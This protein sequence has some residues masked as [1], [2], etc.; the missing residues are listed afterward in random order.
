VVVERKVEKVVKEANNMYCADDII[1][2]AEEVLK[3]HSK[4]GCSLLGKITKC[5]LDKN[6]YCIHA[7]RQSE[8]MHY[9]ICNCDLCITAIRVLIECKGE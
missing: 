1:K 5:S 4:K 6:S 2:L 3:L 7:K 8:C 9:T